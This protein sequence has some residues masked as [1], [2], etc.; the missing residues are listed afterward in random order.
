M[1]AGSPS[2]PGVAASVFG[3]AL[4]AAERYVARLATDGVTRALAVPALATLLARSGTAAGDLVRAAA[5]A[6]GRDDATALLA[7]M[8][9]D[10][11]DVDLD[12]RYVGEGAR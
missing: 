5:D 12:T 3:D 2:V 1:S 4:P 11:A 7:A 9:M 10:T 6:G 8:P